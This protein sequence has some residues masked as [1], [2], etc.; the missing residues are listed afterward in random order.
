MFRNRSRVKKSS[1]LKEVSKIEIQLAV[2]K[3]FDTEKA[4]KTYKR[5]LTGYAVN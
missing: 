1:K 4:G 5:P 2:D 3:F